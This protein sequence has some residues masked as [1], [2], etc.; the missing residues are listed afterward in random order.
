M[1][2]CWRFTSEPEIRG[3]RNS[4]LFVLVCVLVFTFCCDARRGAW[5]MS[6]EAA[7]VRL[8]LCD[9]T[10][11]RGKYNFQCYSLYF[12][13]GESYCCS[14][15]GGHCLRA[16]LR[17]TWRNVYHSA[18]KINSNTAHR[19]WNP[20]PPASGL[21]PEAC[22]AS[23]TGPRPRSRCSVDCCW[24]PPKNTSLRRTNARLRHNWVPRHL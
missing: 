17:C 19:K 21:M 7:A 5:D 22:P 12:L 15:H 24:C 6:R 11:Q 13:D 4:G 14:M 2:G 16:C 3:I 8:E 23:C 10:L 1:I 20:A 9:S 18:S